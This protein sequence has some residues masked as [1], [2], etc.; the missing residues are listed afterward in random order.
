MINY[1]L[2]YVSDAQEL[3]KLNELFNPKKCMTLESIESLLQES[4]QVVVCV[5][6]DRNS[7]VGFSCSYILKFM[8]YTF[9]YGEITEFFVM[10]EYRQ[11]GIGKHLLMFT[12][13]ELN[14]RGVKD[15]YVLT[16]QK[17]IAAQSLYMSCG[18]ADALEILYQ[19]NNK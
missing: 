4:E 10:K 3:K 15:F 18:F 19:K 13:D 9:L 17:N 1:R 2:A 11:Q 16:G 8:C 14:K 12:E 7:L 5:A 6:T